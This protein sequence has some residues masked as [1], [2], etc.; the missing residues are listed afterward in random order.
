M[1]NNYNSEYIKFRNQYYKNH[2]EMLDATNA[3]TGQKRQ[4]QMNEVFQKL[5]QNKY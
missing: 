2:P 5:I 3:E 1:K 4:K